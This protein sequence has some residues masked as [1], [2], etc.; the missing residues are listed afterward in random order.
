[1]KLHSINANQ[2][3]FV[4]EAGTGFSCIGFHVAH[5]KTLAIAEWLKR[6]DLK[7]EAPRGTMK[8]WAEYCKAFKAAQDHYGATKERCPVELESRLVGLEGRRVEVRE[9][10]ERPRRFWVGK[11]TGWM[12]CHLEISRK[13]SSGGCAAYLPESATLTVIR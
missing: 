6:D 7:P 4:L 1:M 2:S 11:S 5:R 9:L 13:G 10:G 8:A 3:L 12:P